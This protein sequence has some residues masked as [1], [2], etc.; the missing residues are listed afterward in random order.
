MHREVRPTRSRSVDFVN[1]DL[2][3]SRV[4]GHG[5]ANADDEVAAGGQ[6]MGAAPVQDEVA[7]LRAGVVLRAWGPA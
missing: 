1:F 5:A 2:V 4:I 7:G 3:M 6:A